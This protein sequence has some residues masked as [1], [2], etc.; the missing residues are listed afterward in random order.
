MRD[1][2][3]VPRGVHVLRVANGAFIEHDADP[4]LVVQ[5]DLGA[6]A[7]SV[8]ERELFERYR[9]RVLA[10]GAAMIESPQLVRDEVTG[11]WCP[12]G[13]ALRCSV[14]PGSDGPSVWVDQDEL[15]LWE[16]GALLEAH[17]ASVIFMFLDD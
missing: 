11:R 10:L 1:L 9:Q 6:H 14:E 7:A 15:S 4:T 17:G 13:R 3:H 2:P 8:G 16:L 5:I 12:H